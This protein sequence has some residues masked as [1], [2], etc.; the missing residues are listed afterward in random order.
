MSDN[1][2]TWLINPRSCFAVCS[3][4]GTSG[5]DQVDSEADTWLSLLKTMR[6]TLK[7]KRFSQASSLVS[8]PAPQDASGVRQIRF[9]RTGWLERAPDLLLLSRARCFAYHDLPLLDFSYRENA[10]N[11]G[12]CS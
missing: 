10:P 7:G 3:W 8:M 12:K 1:R 6:D 4:F 11:P 9:A 5:N 2:L